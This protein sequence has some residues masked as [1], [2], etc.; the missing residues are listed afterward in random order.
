MTFQTMPRFQGQQVV[1]L[2]NQ[3]EFLTY[4]AP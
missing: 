3:R 2:C 4:Q 1:T